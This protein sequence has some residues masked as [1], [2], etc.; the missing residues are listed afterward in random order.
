MFWP[1]WPSSGVQVLVVQES[2]VHCNAVFLSSY[3]YFWLCG[4]HMVAFD[5]IQFTGCG[6][7][8]CSCWGGSSAVC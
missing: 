6:C 8:E 7:L 1:K 3:C 2:A 4:L 5:F